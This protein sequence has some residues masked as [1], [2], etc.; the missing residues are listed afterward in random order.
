[1]IGVRA[2]IWALLGQL[3]NAELKP[4]RYACDQ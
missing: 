3:A 1:M 4:Q 2:K